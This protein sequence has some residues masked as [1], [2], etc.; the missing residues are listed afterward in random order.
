MIAE[1]TFHR[2]DNEALIVYSKSAANASDAVLVA[3][4][5]D[6]HHTQS[7]WLDLD[8]NALGVEG[9]R[10]FQVHDLLSESRFLWKGARNFV[11]LDPQVS[12]VHILRVRRRVRTERD[13]DYFL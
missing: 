2:S 7:G 10:S 13:F 4:N 5:L 1:L 11:V 9:D 6:P 8:L 12:P 3:V